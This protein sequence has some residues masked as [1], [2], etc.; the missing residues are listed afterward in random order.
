LG[1]GPRLMPLFLK[2]LREVAYGE[3]AK[4]KN[5]DKKTPGSP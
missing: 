3:T 5:P 1:H 2:L 4:P